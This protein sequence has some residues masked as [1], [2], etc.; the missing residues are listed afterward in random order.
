V[1]SQ[2]VVAAAKRLWRR[3]R[4]G[5]SNGDRPTRK[6]PKPDWSLE[7]ATPKPGRVPG[8]PTLRLHIGIESVDDLNA[9]LDRGSA[10]R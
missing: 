6:N 2:S 9:D 7:P 1:F 3:E 8:G 5:F 10:R 4:M